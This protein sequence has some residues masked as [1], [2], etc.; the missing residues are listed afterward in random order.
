MVRVMGDMVRAWSIAMAV[1]MQRRGWGMGWRG[2][3][4]TKIICKLLGALGIEQKASGLMISMCLI[5]YFV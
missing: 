2:I 1:M 4:E 5:F 3:Q